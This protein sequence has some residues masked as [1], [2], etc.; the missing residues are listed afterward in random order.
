MCSLL[1]SDTRYH[2]V[3]GAPACR[4]GGQGAV[5]TPPHA[6][7]HALSA[8]TPASLLAHGALRRGWNSVPCS[9][10][11]SWPATLA[12]STVYQAVPCGMVRQQAPPR[13]MTCLP[14]SGSA[15]HRAPDLARR[16][17]PCD[18]DHTW[19]GEPFA[20]GLGH[21]RQEQGRS[22]VL[23]SS[24]R[25]ARSDGSL[26][27][28]PAVRTGRGTGHTECSRPA[29]RACSMAVTRRPRGVEAQQGNPALVE[30]VSKDKLR[31]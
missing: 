7:P 3:R 30:E 14:S 17:W 20:A 29:T 4:H 22:R 1:C 27:G 25:G 23:C 6:Q 21:T 15:S 9:T 16:R 26:S 10:R 8:S 31:T 19:S 28:L 18:H 12:P 13:A 24:T 2:S 5:A 11:G